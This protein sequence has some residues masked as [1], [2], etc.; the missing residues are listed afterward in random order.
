M[1]AKE[2]KDLGGIYLENVED[3][4][5]GYKNEIRKMEAFAA[6]NTLEGLCLKHG[7]EISFADFYYHT[8]DEEVQ[9]N[10]EGALE[11]EEIEYIKEKCN[12]RYRDELIFP[13]DPTLLRIIVK[14]NAREILFSTLYFVGENRST[15]WGNYSKEYI[16][17]TD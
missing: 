14:L 2:L 16:V 17:F 10:I 9:E 13:L 7:W 8:F 6:Y 3:G 12:P 1:T 15:W 4:L 11:E 5:R